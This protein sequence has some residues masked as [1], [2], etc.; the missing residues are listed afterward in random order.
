MQE[1]VTQEA[2]PKRAMDA[3]EW[4]VQRAEKAEV[5]P[6]GAASEQRPSS[7]RVISGRPADFKAA[8]ALYL[9]D[10]RK[11]LDRI[12]MS[13]DAESGLDALLESGALAAMLPEVEA[14]VGFGDGEWRHKDVWKHT[15]QVVRQAVPRL[16]V[17]WAALLH[18]IG[19]TRTRSISP[20]GEVHFF[21]HAEV[22]ARMFDKIDRRLPLFA[23][24]TP[25]KSSIRF[26]IL[27]HLRAS[28]YDPS[29]TDSAV[30]RF[31]K[32]MGGCLS[33]VLDLSRADI[34]TKRPEKKR[35][36][37][38]QISELAER[39]L[40]V[41]AEDAVVPPLPSGIGDAIMQAFAIPPS[42]RIGE[43]KRALEEAVES[44]EVASHQE[45]EVYLA[46]LR[47]NAARFGL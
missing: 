8:A 37:L 40:Q 25:L 26:L 43:L 6:S 35:K 29:W 12:M 1:I 17:R 21:G 15:K 33:D 13:E 20:T 46:F 7:P 23:K 3:L 19:K 28:Q 39:V 36:G 44:G 47:D 34:T 10:V 45:A 5:E 2:S 14:M 27:H 16:E 11:L 32:E 4:A 18:D 31:A 38:K 24:E 41:Q 30:R 42:R 9:P 22:G